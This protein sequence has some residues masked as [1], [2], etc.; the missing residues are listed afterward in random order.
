M[1]K[2]LN[3]LSA[4][5]INQ[6]LSVWDLHA[7]G[8]KA[9]KILRLEAATKEKYPD[10]IPT[11]FDFSKIL[12]PHSQSTTSNF[13]STEQV[14]ACG[15]TMNMAEMMA[16]FQ[17]MLN[18]FSDVSQESRSNTPTTTRTHRDDSQSEIQSAKHVSLCS[19][20][21]NDPELWFITAEQKF[22]SYGITSKDV[23]FG[24]VV[25]ALDSSI[26]VQVANIMKD[27]TL[28]NKYDA[29]KKQLI[30]IYKTSE[31]NKIQKILSEAFLGDKKPSQ[32]YREM[33]D[34]A[35]NK[36]AED[37]LLSLWM[38]KLTPQIEQNLRGLRTISTSDQILLIA[39]GMVECSGSRVDAIKESTQ[40]NLMKEVSTKLDKVIELLES[41]FQPRQSRPTSRSNSRNSRTNSFE[42][43]CYYHRRF[44]DKATKCISP[45]SFSATSSENRNANH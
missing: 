29:V 5:E 25:D 39:D 27:P 26:I 42:K 43:H 30:D 37:F 21:K 7:G 11:T 9:D 40:D 12:Q 6:I 24:K 38:K 20:W 18:R 32:L 35:C 16:Q 15:G 23:K 2:L 10:S 36:I 34:L 31:E 19:F 44:K 28:E 22:I 1:E 17:V 45:C 41:R 14:G 8:S 13:E 3:D 4:A 33:K